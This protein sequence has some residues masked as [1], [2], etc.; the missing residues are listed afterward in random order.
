MLLCGN[1]Y[2]KWQ[3][4]ATLL[5]YWSLPGIGT[6]PESNPGSQSSFDVTTKLQACQTVKG[7][8]QHT[9]EGQRLA[10]HGG[11]PRSAKRRE[12]ATAIE[13]FSDPTR[14]LGVP[15]PAPRTMTEAIDHDAGGS[16]TPAAYW[17][18]IAKHPRFIRSLFSLVLIRF[19]ITSGLINVCC[20]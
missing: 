16:T 11:S 18:S 15:L 3:P 1:K 17:P 7:I 4:A 14:V 6:F 13:T 8:N 19:A 12:S 2:G 5:W 20:N 10:R 9:L